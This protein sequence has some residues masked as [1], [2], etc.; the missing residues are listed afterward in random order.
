[1]RSIRF[2]AIAVVLLMVAGLGFAAILVAKG[3][4]GGSR[5][6]RFHFRS[7][8]LK[9]FLLGLLALA[10]L[11]LV[12]AGS[13]PTAPAR[14]GPHV[15]RV[16]VKFRPGTNQRD[17]AQ[18]NATNSATVASTIPN[19]VCCGCPSRESA[20]NVAAPTRKP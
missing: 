15:R 10:P 18:L 4:N 16:L 14:H 13:E 11:L 17:I 5:G 1:M 2:A 19:S 7:K 8:L 6:S 3:P 20:E 12:G 9:V